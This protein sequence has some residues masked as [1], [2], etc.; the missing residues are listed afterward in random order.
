MPKEYYLRAIKKFLEMQEDNHYVLNVLEMCIDE[1]EVD[2]EK[3][4]FGDGYCLLE[5]IR[6]ELDED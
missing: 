4:F 6:N 5:E 1:N 3:D 2:A